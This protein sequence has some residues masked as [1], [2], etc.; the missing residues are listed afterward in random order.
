MSFYRTDE[1]YFCGQIENVR[2]SLLCI[3]ALSICLNSASLSRRRSICPPTRLHLLIRHS[4]GSVHYLARDLRVR[5]HFL[6]ISSELDE[7]STMVD[8]FF[9]SMRRL[10]GDVRK[11]MTNG[12]PS[13]SDETELNS[14]GRVR[15][16]FI[17]VR[18]RV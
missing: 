9:Q 13:L 3:A 12:C 14:L 11:S 6:V 18:R 16:R 5:F 7:L 10:T 1:R 4:S 17:F 8:V 2:E 15:G